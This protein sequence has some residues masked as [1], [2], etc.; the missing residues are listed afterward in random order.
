VPGLPELDEAPEAVEV[1]DDPPPTAAPKPKVKARAKGK[2]QALHH[3]QLARRKG[4]QR[5]AGAS[6]WVVLSR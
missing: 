4:D 5:F 2:K 3:C 1:A 6:C